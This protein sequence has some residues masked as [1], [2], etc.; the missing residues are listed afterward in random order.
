MDCYLR[1]H[2]YD[3]LWL[4][5]KIIILKLTLIHVLPTQ[6]I[7]LAGNNFVTRDILIGLQNFKELLIIS[8]FN[9]LSKITLAGMHPYDMY[10]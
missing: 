10:H 8:F 4:V 3:D 5:Q 7:T 1:L 9:S 2:F 6:I